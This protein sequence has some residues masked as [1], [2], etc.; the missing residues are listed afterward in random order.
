MAQ[1][2]PPSIC[3]QSIIFDRVKF[4]L[5]LFYCV[6]SLILI[7]AWQQVFHLPFILIPLH[8]VVAVMVHSLS[9]LFIAALSRVVRSRILAAILIG[10]YTVKVLLFYTLIFGSVHYWGDI[11][12]VK[13]LGSYLKDF[14][15]FL[16][17]LPFSYTEAMAA[18]F[19]F[20]ALPVILA[21]L[22]SKK[23][24]PAVDDLWSAMTANKKMALIIIVM[25]GLASPL[26]LKGKRFI[27][28]R[29]E[30]L[31]VML[32]DHMWGIR[33]NP[34]F[35]QRRIDVGFKDNQLRKEYAQATQATAKKN[36]ILIIVDAL[37][38]DHLSAYSYERNTSPYLKQ[39]ID[40]HKAVKVDK[41]YS[42]CANT[43][44]GVTSILL[45]R[46]WED[47]AVNGFNVIGLLHDQG[48]HTYTLISGAHK[49]WY[50]MAKFYS[51]DCTMYYDGKQSQKYYFKDDRV[52]LEGLD[53]V[54]A[55]SDKPAFFYLH[56]QSTHETGMLQ[57]KYTVYKPF[58]K[59]ITT[60]GMNGTAAVNE[61]DDKVLQADD[62]IRQL[63]ESLEQKGYLK[64]SIVVITSDHGQGLGEHGVSGHVDWLYDPQTSVPLIIYDD[65]LVLYKNL[66]LANHI[67]IAPTI[68]ERIGLPKPKSWMG[69]SL[70]KPD[71]TQYS[72]HE[73]GKDQL[74]TGEAKYMIVYHQDSAVYKYIYTAGFKKEELYNVM[75]DPL[76]KKNLASSDKRMR[77]LMREKTDM[78]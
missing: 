5:L 53:K 39:L 60:Q 48:Y 59:S 56:L 23:I 40:D 25:L 37:R 31:M 18:I 22:L 74:E 42:T 54:P 8:L 15:S 44:C 71:I 72:Y 14:R 34:L 57:D 27:H 12:T 65:S 29:G 46:T 28:L 16:H 38:A 49:E 33:D 67:D 7:T 61:Y 58:K 10:I 47:C 75:A 13:I 55:Y 52:L 32:F 35:S 6:L 62:M 19:V 51:D 26:L 11:I 17:S 36:V 68:V 63:M 24:A 43:L 64:N 78:H 69:V 3:L 73:T 20:I 4:R 41:C 1:G 66:T 77:D 2:L 21:L 9:L 50:N 45:S 30:P 70:T 76:E